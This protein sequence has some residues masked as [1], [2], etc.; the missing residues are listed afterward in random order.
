[1]EPGSS[2]TEGPHSLPQPVHDV[3][4]PPRRHIK[5]AVVGSGLAGLTAAYILSRQNER[6]LDVEFDVHLFEK[7]S[8]LGMDAQSVSVP[9]ENGEKLRVDVPMR[10][11]QGGY[12]RHLIALYTHLDI[13]LKCVDFTYSFSHLRGLVTP[14]ELPVMGTYFI[15]NG[16]N[17]KRGL[18]LPSQYLWYYPAGQSIRAAI[19]DF[20]STKLMPLLGFTWATLMFFACY[21][22]LIILSTPA[23]RLSLWG[24]PAGETLAAWGK[25]TTPRDIISAW[26][27]FD[28]AWDEFV[29]QVVLIMFSAMCTSS[30]E[31]LWA[32]PVE[33][34]LDYTWL[35]LFAN[36]FVVA[37]G[38]QDVV[39][40]L[41]CRINPANVHLSSPIIQVLPDPTSS[42][43]LRIATQAVPILSTYLERLPHAEKQRLEINRIIECLRNFEYRKNIVV[44][45]TDTRLVPPDERDRRDLNLIRLQPLQD[46]PSPGVPFLSKSY[47]SVPPTFTMTTHS[48]KSDSSSQ[49]IYQSTNPIIA[50]SSSKVL[51]VAY[52][53]RPILTVR[54]ESAVRDLSMDDPRRAAWWDL[55]R[56][57]PKAKV[58]GALQGGGRRRDVGW[59]RPLPGI[60]ICGSYAYEGIPLLEGCVASARMV[61]EQGVMRSEGL[62]AWDVLA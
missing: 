50:P 62:D 23:W 60:W 36:H 40:R 38:V 46:S 55:L 28:V 8:S 7:A 16:Q 53:D 22:R 12:Y 25:R 56:G 31:D 32:H 14:T 59:D 57:R 47:L 48:V 54:S 43:K 33:A 18:G 34:I 58:L 30:A 26:V 9:L 39:R 10:S 41:S 20:T 3:V 11:F 17:G 44:T 29:R 13:Q 5:V 49:F 42:G 21:V 24:S 1:M 51:S 6:Q 52:M 45:H 37:N 15:Y 61:I 19:K 35:T 4:H 2:K 27:G